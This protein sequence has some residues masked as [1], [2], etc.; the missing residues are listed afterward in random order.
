M[1]SLTEKFNELRG[2]LKSG[3]GSIRPTGFDPVY[4]LLFPSHQIIEVKQRLPAWEAQLKVDSFQ[5]QH[6]SMTAVLNDYF[7]THDLR[8]PL[9]EAARLQSND[10]SVIMQSLTTH[11][12]ND[13][14]VGAAILRA[15]EEHQ[16]DPASV[17]FLTDLEALHPFLRIGAVEQQLLGRFSFPTIVLYPGTAGGAYSRR[18]LGV[19]KEDGN[20]RSPHID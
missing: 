1:R 18:F 13:N 15:I 10:F 16:N 5:P 12:V 11:L 2:Q 9:L 14:V 8:E 3:M 20:Y 19:H 17:L 6:L 7:Q 4:Y